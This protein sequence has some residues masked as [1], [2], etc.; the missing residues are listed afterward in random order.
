MRRLISCEYK[1]D[2]SCVE[3]IYTD[4]SMLAIDVSTEE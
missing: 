4:G 3:L 2:T 1:M